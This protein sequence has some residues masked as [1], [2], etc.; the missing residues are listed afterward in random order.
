MAIYSD[1][2][3]FYSDSMGCYW[4]LPSGKHTKKH[5]NRIK[6]GKYPLVNKH[7]D[8]ENNPFLMETNLP[9]PTCQGLCEFSRG[10]LQIIGEIAIKYWGK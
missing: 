3:G 9:S 6:Q 4:D 10:Y 7:V 2:M 1:L 8:P 5:T